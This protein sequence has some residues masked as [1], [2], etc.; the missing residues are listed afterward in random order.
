MFSDDPAAGSIK[1][2][3]TEIQNINLNSLRSVI[4]LV[5]QEPQLLCVPARYCV[6]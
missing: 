2:D 4:S 1:L 6:S 3:G 5:G